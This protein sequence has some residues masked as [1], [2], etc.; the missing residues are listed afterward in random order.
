MDW[1]IHIGYQKTGSKALQK[2]F[3]HEPQ[4]RPGTTLVYP[5]SGRA[6]LWHRPLHDELVAGRVDSLRAAIEE[7]TRAG[8]R[9]A[10]LSFEGFSTMPGEAV[11]L[12]RRELG[13]ATVVIF[14]RKQDDL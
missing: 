6:G 8:S 12:L 9:F 5:R 14:L 2:F 7:A 10:V 4:R 3:A 13:E 11:S 1:I